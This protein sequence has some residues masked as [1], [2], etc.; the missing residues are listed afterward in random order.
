[1]G[2]MDSKRITKEEK[3]RR[4]K[5]LRAFRENEKTKVWNKSLD[6]VG[7]PNPDTPEEEWYSFD[8][9]DPEPDPEFDDLVEDYP[10]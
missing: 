10:N 9:L 1:M 5:L 4:K 8:F 2:K 3:T 7:P 6:E